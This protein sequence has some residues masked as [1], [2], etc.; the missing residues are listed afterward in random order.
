VTCVPGAVSVL[1]HSTAL[2][3]LALGVVTLGTALHP[4]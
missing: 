3:H 1:P 4:S 2:C